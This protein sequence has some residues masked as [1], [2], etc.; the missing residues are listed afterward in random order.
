MKR[1]MVTLSPVQYYC[2]IPGVN[3]YAT[4]EE[5]IRNSIHIAQLSETYGIVGSLSFFNHGVLDPWAV[6]SIVIQQTASHIPLIAV[7]P[8]MYPPYT[9]A[10]LIHSFAYLY[11]RRI[12]LNMITG[13]VTGE[14]QQIGDHSDHSSRYRKLHEYV[15]VL[16]MLLESDAPVTF[17]GDYYRV[18]KLDFKPRLA[19]ECLRPK[20][21]MAGSSEEG[22]ETGLK[23]ADYVVTHPGPL[24]HFKASFSEKFRNTEVQ[25]AIRLEIIARPS[26][27]EAWKA[28]YSRYPSNRHGSIQLRLKR[29]SESSWQRTLAELALASETYDEVFWMG[30]YMNGGIYSP[31]LVGDYEQ[32]ARYLNGYYA[33]GVKAV[34]LGSMYSEEDFV[35]FNQVKSILHYASSTIGEGN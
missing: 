8:Y 22:M 21:F 28:A 33:L 15:Q 20:I 26:S 6:S 18:S 9:V 32:V 25:A 29:N 13:A 1:E 35:H 19:D 23:V 16:R 24:E 14:L 5:Y 17:E 12:D 11:N 27:A 3:H 34:L 30:G 31:V 2:Q 4:K 10:K 7:Q